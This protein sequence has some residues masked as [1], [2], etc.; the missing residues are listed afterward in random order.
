M[1]LSQSKETFVPQTFEPKTFK[2]NEYVRPCK[3]ETI[4]YLHFHKNGHIIKT[5]KSEN[6]K[7]I[8]SQLI[9]LR[10]KTFYDYTIYIKSGKSEYIYSAQM[11]TSNYIK[12]IYLYTP[13]QEIPLREEH[14]RLEQ[15]RFVAF[16]E[17]EKQR[18]IEHNLNE[19][20]RWEAFQLIHD[21]KSDEPPPKYQDV[22]HIKETAPLLE[23]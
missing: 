5:F 9:P 12:Q 15:N 8:T 4:K 22:D 16:Q 11:K 2:K 14:D 1:G 18:R 13:E 17:E 19:K 7:K 23:M 3:E 21:K 20:R 6:V 10:G